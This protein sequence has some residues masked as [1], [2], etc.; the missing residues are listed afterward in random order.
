MSMCRCEMCKEIID[1]DLC[2]GCVCEGCQAELD[3]MDLEDQLETLLDK[4]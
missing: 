1:S 4:A 3:G 2:E